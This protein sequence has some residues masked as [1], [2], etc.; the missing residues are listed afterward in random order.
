[1]RWI[2][3]LHELKQSWTKTW[4]R[5][6]KQ[7]NFRAPCFILKANMTKHHIHKCK[8]T[9]M[10]LSQSCHKF[11][12]PIIYQSMLLPSFT[13]SRRESTCFNIGYCL[14]FYKK[15]RIDKEN[16]CKCKDD[17]DDRAMTWLLQVSGIL[18][19]PVGDS[20]TNL[21]IGSKVDMRVLNHTRIVLHIMNNNSLHA[22]KGESR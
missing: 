6:L 14:E 18:V 19:R 3:Q 17:A 15:Q 21:Q 5:A 7:S 4:A 2:H 22:Q 13:Y 12:Q 16:E 9:S 8:K 11:L 10:D 1:M 20:I